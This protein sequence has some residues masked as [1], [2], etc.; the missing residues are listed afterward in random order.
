MNRTRKG[1]LINTPN[2][3]RR[4]SGVMLV[5]MLIAVLVLS[6]MM[7]G[8]MQGLSQMHT[9]GTATQN[10]VIA[11][12]IAQEL[13]DQARNAQ[14]TTISSPAIADGAWHN[15]AV[16][17]SPLSDQPSYLP[18]ALMYDGTSTQG[19]NNHFRGTVRQM[20]TGMGGGQVQLTV[21]VNWPAETSGGAT[22]SLQ[23]TSYISQWGIHN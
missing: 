12:N 1:V 14:W 22:R 4:D 17:G 10:Q 23:A 3:L 18:R 6:I 16:Y 9:G 19:L 21:Q 11:A 13:V 5:E 8:I 15:V 7:A 20:V 2:S